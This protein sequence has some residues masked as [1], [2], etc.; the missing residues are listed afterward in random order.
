MIASFA[1]V[2]ALF[3]AGA[4][5]ASP[6]K[7]DSHDD[8]VATAKTMA[9][10]LMG[11]Y[12]GNKT[13]EIPGI[14]PGPPPNGQYY[15]W[16]AAVF[17]SSFIDYWH[18]TGDSQYNDLV[19]EGM[20]WQTGQ[21][22]NFLPANWT[23][24]MGNDDQCIWAIAA[25]DATDAGLPDPKDAPKWSTLA[26]NVFE[27]MV[28]RYQDEELC[29]GGLRWQI[30]LSNL[31]YDYKD[32]VSNGCYFNLASRLF[33]ATGN[34][35]Y[36]DAAQ[37]VYDWMV[38]IGY[39]DEKTWAIYNGGHTGENCTDINKALFSYP[40]AHIIQG[41]SFM[42]NKTSGDAQTKWKSN[43]DNILDATLK[44]F[45]PNG[46]AF[47]AA[48]EE[49][50]TCT[51]DM[52]SF[53]GVLHRFLAATT[54]TAPYTA[55]KITPILTSS[56]KAAVNQC[57]GGD[58]G[59]MCGFHWGD[60]NGEYYISTTDGL[61]EQLSTL[62]A[63]ESLLMVASNNGTGGAGGGSGSGN[64]NG[65]GS[66]SGSGEPGKPS[67]AGRMGAMGWWVAVAGLAV[68]FAL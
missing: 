7:I 42:Y 51:T 2:A 13:G 38:K 20:L 67:S 59:R 47:E 31:G 41:A 62:G 23:A 52:I 34:S 18:L 49:K 27:N 45:F 8:I 4:L 22:E 56:A 26:T 17:W 15:W 37:K 28:S 48:C 44:T 21:N 35:T 1:G 57:T 40:A 12:Q 5:A 29:G 16:N 68:A 58:N 60:V 3:G 30:P 63:V 14:L 6:F 39:I 53:K 65:S 64:G 9:H 61:G 50:D 43:L 33:K 19:T 36:S 46:I 66:G 24:S 10:D 54:A 11:L 55:G 25:L 32:T